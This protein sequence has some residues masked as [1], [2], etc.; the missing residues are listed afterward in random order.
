M[1]AAK[2]NY[3]GDQAAPAWRPCNSVRPT[4]EAC[5]MTRAP[6]TAEIYSSHVPALATLVAMG[7]SYIPSAECMAARGGSQSVLLIPF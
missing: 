1:Q 7:W 4:R 3:D 2:V 5:E 6:S